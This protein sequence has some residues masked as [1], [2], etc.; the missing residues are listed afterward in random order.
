MA[1]QNRR[2]I[3][4]GNSFQ[5]GPIIPFWETALL[6]WVWK[7]HITDKKKLMPFPLKNDGYLLNRFT[8]KIAVYCNYTF[9]I[10][11]ALN[12]IPFSTE[13]NN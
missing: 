7:H 9:P 3:R 4:S 12:R 11:S 6:I 10:D 13:I 8:V 5:F 2:K 1:V